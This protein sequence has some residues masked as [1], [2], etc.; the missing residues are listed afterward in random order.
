MIQIRPATERDF[1]CLLDVEGDAAQLFANFGLVA[2]A[3]FAPSPEDFY[4]S[5]PEESIVLVAVDNVRIV[6][7]SVGI[8]VDG[9]SYLREVSVRRS[10]AKQGIGKRLVQG[11]MQ[12]AVAHG[13]HTMTLT[14]FRDLPFNG[15]FYN[16]LGFQEFIPDNAW[17]ELCQI[18]EKEKRGGLEVSPRIAM[19]LHLVNLKIE[20]RPSCP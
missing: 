6:G 12:W 19:R 2:I 5:L 15:P 13:F 18:R 9:Q 10:Y 1:P 3:A 16:N 7:F 20:A 4:R 17:P 11:V 8:V 14:T